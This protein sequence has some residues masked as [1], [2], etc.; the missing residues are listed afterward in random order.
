MVAVFGG[1]VTRGKESNVAGLPDGD[2]FHA[3]KHFQHERSVLHSEK[4]HRED[5]IDEAGKAKEKRE[6]SCARAGREKKRGSAA[7]P[8]GK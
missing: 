2:P 4:Q 8:R 7:P 5:G 3:R 1:A 6:H